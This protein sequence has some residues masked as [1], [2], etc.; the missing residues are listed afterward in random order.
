[1]AYTYTNR[2]VVPSE[3]LQIVGAWMLVLLTAQAIELGSFSEAFA[4][5]ADLA[6]ALL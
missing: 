4:Q 2:M 5:N 6:K 1:M 3:V